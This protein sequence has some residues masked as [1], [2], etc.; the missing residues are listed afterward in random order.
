MKDYFKSGGAFGTNINI[1]KF[2]SQ[3]TETSSFVWTSE[4]IDRLIDDCSTGAADVNSV[5]PSPFFDNDTSLRKAK[6][7]FQ[8][9]SQEQ[10]EFKR[11]CIDPIYFIEKFC[12]FKTNKGYESVKLRDYQYGIIDTYHRNRFSILMSSRQSGKTV[13]SSAYL[14]WYAITNHD[15]NILI[16]GNILQTSLENLDK[17]KNMIY[18]LPFYLK[19]GI[20][21]INE[22]MIEFE[23]GSRIICRATTKKSAVG[24]S[25][26]VLYLDEFALV[27]DSI[28]EDFYSSV[29][30][31]VSGMPESKIIISSTPRGLNLFYKLWTDAISGKGNEYGDV[32]APMRVDWWQI[33]GRDELWK[34]RTII[35]IGS[36]EAFNREYGLQFYSTDDKLLDGTD[37]RKLSSLK[38]KFESI[39]I[40]C[41]N[42]TEVIP[43]G[44]G[45]YRNI[46]VNYSK[47]MKWHPKFIEKYL[48]SHRPNI[49]YDN[50]NYYVISID[51][52]KGV[53]V[54]YSIINIFKI[55]PLPAARL[56]KNRSNIVDDIDI[57][58]AVQVGMFACNSV[59]IECMANIV[60]DLVFEFFNYDR[61]KIVLEL[62]HQGA[63]IRD[64][65]KRHDR[66]YEN[67]FVWTKRNDRSTFADEMGIDINSNK[68]K[69]KYCE[70]FKYYVSIDRIVVSEDET[71]GELSQFGSSRGGTVFRCETGH[72]DKAM[73]CITLSCLFESPQFYSMCEELKFNICDPQYLRIL[74]DQLNINS[75]QYGG[76]NGNS[77]VGVRDLIGLGF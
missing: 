8:L 71:I 7:T 18:N 51:T 44:D 31:T 58:G 34:E 21:K 41:L 56:V 55:A 33:P 26:N 54:D 35:Q 36:E 20:R 50:E 59:N 74:N 61:V 27:D 16:L 29:F 77:R 68:K 14:L 15:K 73:S 13:C 9:S 28:L 63:L 45:R 64:R 49:V 65:I 17:I 37:I 4:K 52:S 46:K 60:T 43:E 1:S 57:F 22:K 6:I 70:K 72:D 25:I 62:N 38:T 30:P 66:F 32:Y 23:N 5:K 10:T 75:G 39:N 67:M 11:C 47:F 2:E 48:P 40:D 76:S 12:K 53:G 69:M 24:L 19:P 42:M 3:E